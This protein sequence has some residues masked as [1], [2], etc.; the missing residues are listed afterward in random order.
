METT[1]AYNNEEQPPAKN[2]GFVSGLAIIVSYIF[3]PLFIAV[4]ITA[5]LTY[6]H[7][8]AF[9]ATSTF[10]KARTLLSVFI[11]TAFFPALVVLLLKQLKFINSI[12]LNTQKD[13]IIP[14]IAS[15]IF[16]FWAFYVSKNIA[17]TPAL[18]TQ[19]LLATFLTSI[20]ALMCNIKFKISLHGL[21]AG[22]AFC[23]FVLMA[24]STGVSL[25]LYVS[26]VTFIAGLV[27]TARLI[28]SNHAVS[29]VY[30]GFF[31]GMC[32]QLVAAFFIAA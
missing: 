27:C 14:I 4:Y 8:T 23:F 11:N 3:H 13:R 16:Y 2:S 29:D 12:Q 31:L 32:C 19:V 7:P 21:A 22:V 30:A 28:V 6:L 9:A 24:I 17:G 10:E 26:I 5:F 20:V 25:G 15:M 18:L 1:T